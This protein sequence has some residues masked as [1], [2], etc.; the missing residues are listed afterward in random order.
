MYTCYVL[1][2]RFYLYIVCL[3]L[4][5]PLFAQTADTARDTT[6]DEVADNMLIYQ[7]TVGGWPKHIGNEPIDY[8]KKL[9]PAEK[10]AFFDDASMNDATIDNDATSKE[11]R[12]LAAA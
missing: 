1:K 7:R 11:I 3:F 12:Y 8:R 6:H 5:A 2:M 10:A 9:S 4:G